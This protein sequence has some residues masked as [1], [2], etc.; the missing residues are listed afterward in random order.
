MRQKPGNML[1]ITEDTPADMLSGAMDLTIHLPSGKAVKMCVERR[2][3]MMDLL[4][5]VTT[6]HQ[7]QI[8]NYTL[9]PLQ[10]SSS[11]NYS[12]KVL[13]YYPNTPI[14]ALDTQYM[15]VIPKARILPN[16]KNLPPGT[17]PF[18]TT[19]RLKVHLP[20]NQL[21]VTRVSK[22]IHIGDIMR[23]V[24][25]EK[26]LDPNKYEVRHPGNLEEILDPKLTL[27]D[28]MIT[29]INLVVKGSKTNTHTFTSEDIMSLRKNEERK[30]I[31]SKPGGVFSL[32]FRRGKSNN[33]P[34][35]SKEYTPPPSKEDQ[36]SKLAPSTVPIV[37]KVPQRKRRPAPK[38][39]QTVDKIPPP[40]EKLPQEE[41]VQLRSGSVIS[42][43]SNC[44]ENDVKIE[45]GLTIY[46]S[47]HSSDS[48]GYHE[49]SILSDQCNTSLPRRNRLDAGCETMGRKLN[50]YSESTG[51]LTKM[52][53]HSRSTSSLI[54]PGRKKKAAPAPPKPLLKFASST[55]NLE[56][57]SP[58][59]ASQSPLSTSSS[60]TDLYL[61]SQG[62]QNSTN[63][64]PVPRRRKGPTPIP[65]ISFSLTEEDE[66]DSEIP[67]E[68][69]NISQLL[70]DSLYYSPYQT[71]GAPARDTPDNSRPPSNMS[72]IDILKSLEYLNVDDQG[73]EIKP[74]EIIAVLPKSN[75]IQ[76]EA[77]DADL[78]LTKRPFILN[79]VDKDIDDDNTSIATE[80]P[81]KNETTSI[82]TD[83]S[84]IEIAQFQKNV[85]VSKVKSPDSIPFEEERM[86]RW[87]SWEELNQSLSHSPTERTSE[88]SNKENFKTC[89]ESIE[90][91]K[92]EYV[93]KTVDV[94]FSDNFHKE[95]EKLELDQIEIMKEVASQPQFVEEE[96]K[97]T[98][99]EDS[100]GSN[101]RDDNIPGF[102]NNEWCFNGVITDTDVNSTSK[103][104][105]EISVQRNDVIIRENAY[106]TNIMNEISLDDVE[107][108]KNYGNSPDS[109]N[110]SEISE[111]SKTDDEPNI[112]EI[113][114]VLTTNNEVMEEWQLPSPPKAFKDNLPNNQITD[115]EN[116]TDSVITAEL[117][118][119]LER[120]E[121]EQA[122]RTKNE[123]Q[124]S[125][126]TTTNEDNGLILSKLSLENLEIRKSL[127]YNREL[128]TSLKQSYKTEAA[129]EDDF[130]LESLHPRQAK[131]T[132]DLNRRTEI[133][134]KTTN[135]EA[136]S[137][138]VKQS[139]LPN[140][141]ITTYKDESKQI[142]VFE[143]DT[144]RSNSDFS[145]KSLSLNRGLTLQENGLGRSME[146]I[147]IRKHDADDVLKRPE[148]AEKRMFRPKSD[149]YRRSVNRSGSFSVE[150]NEW[151]STKPVARSKSQVALRRIDR[152][153]LSFESSNMSR[154]NSLF[155]VSGLQS[156]EVMKKIQN[157]LNTPTT[158]METLS[159]A[160]VENKSEPKAVKVE[161]NPKKKYQYSPPSVNM[162]TWSDRPKVPVSVK[163]DADYKLGQ[164]TNTRHFKST[165]KNGESYTKDDP[166]QKYYDDFSRTNRPQRVTVICNGS[167]YLH[168]DF[169]GLTRQEDQKKKYSEHNIDTMGR[170]PYGRKTSSQR[171]HSV[172][173]ASDFDIS[174]V[175]VVR[176]VELKKKFRDVSSST[177]VH[178][179]QSS[180]DFRSNGLSE[181][182]KFNTVMN[183]KETKPVMRAKSFLQH[184][185]V[186]RGFRTLENISSDTNTKIE[187][188]NRFS[189]QSNTSMTL[190]STLK[191][192]NMT[193]NH[194]LHSSKYNLRRNES[195]NSKDD[196][197]SV[198]NENL[199]SHNVLPIFSKPV[200]AP[201]LSINIS[202][203]KSTIP[204]PPPLKPNT[205]QKKISNRQFVP[206]LDPRDEL[207]KSIRD[208]GGKKGLRSRKTD[209]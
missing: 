54:F 195:K 48:S 121:K 207:L 55:T 105:H 63:P 27:N 76:E 119:K 29:E 186:V 53:S 129:K 155:D 184:A 98:M 176:S 162:G 149:H 60:K 5:Q 192:D 20:R 15:K 91:T 71:E 30:P 32:L 46:H 12:E 152:K 66:K 68:N 62:T 59:V 42:D 22:H 118:E 126:S 19:F 36:D 81:F 73:N 16:T 141:K 52:T 177:L 100:M 92:D 142:K 40:S 171:P 198:P 147:S 120:I 130:L 74:P 110:S 201:Q 25:E 90:T 161:E 9:Q 77:S 144:I 93:P 112:P 115:T 209:F 164:G 83:F 1:H 104:A 78:I 193:T 163:E 34:P 106:P 113:L 157:K 69:N 58:V 102:H 70:E 206:V 150:Q 88:Y 159:K 185:P 168:N 137:S 123:K 3:P 203:E 139:T 61:A 80:S 38:P 31:P 188:Y 97:S 56:T 86:R 107:R 165:V 33:V 109:G 140:F 89:L 125:S 23:K 132:V 199:A 117:I 41:P 45:P 133:S 196:E 205:V 197:W 4:V 175:P 43:N 47:R 135:T 96:M 18:E 7:L 136:V 158:S 87:G 153:I 95:N 178:L 82:I 57:L 10:T 94:E 145:G 189:W 182:P 8:T 64:P 131:K 51:N 172:A 180:E 72:T 26:N 116:E 13:S 151:S 108:Y 191:K 84:S 17:K 208:F 101:L 103:P 67:L 173:F 44:S 6:N 134:G 170:S 194:N 181:K 124:N 75:H 122:T 156:L 14:G 169:N 128:S 179:N 202:T 99:E 148:E 127:V 187:K 111:K 166:E 79:L 49:T 138:Q 200:E 37:P 39:P 146:N 190:P 28:Y 167:S 143:D 204:K 65:G 114:E 174:R 85:S 24:C 11:D 183:V 21:Y 160:E 50:R 35:S 2:T 154:S